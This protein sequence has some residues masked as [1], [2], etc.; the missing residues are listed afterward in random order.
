MTAAVRL[1]VVATREEAAGHAVGLLTAALARG[2]T[3]RCFL[4]DR[5]VRLLLDGAFC[6]LLGMPNLRVD[7]CEHSWER[8]GD[9]TAGPEGV[10][11]GQYQ[12]AELVHTSD[13]VVVL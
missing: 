6:A 10:M 13:R 4:T 8:F 2:W 5:G 3:C 11:G 1:G 7:V 9:G 12:N